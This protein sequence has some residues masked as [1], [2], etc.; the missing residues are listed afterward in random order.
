[1]L[2]EEITKCLNVSVHLPNSQPADMRR[3]VM[4]MLLHMSQGRCLACADQ[5]QHV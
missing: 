5:V 2:S 1:M 4:I 3:T